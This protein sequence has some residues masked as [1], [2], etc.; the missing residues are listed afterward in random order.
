MPVTPK[1]HVTQTD[2]FVLVSMHVPHVRIANAE[3]YIDCR[4]FTF[5]CKPYLLKLNFPHD[6]VDDED[7][8]RAVFDP[9]ED[10]GTITAHLPKAEPGLYFKDLDLTT[11]LLQPRWTR[12]DLSGEKKDSQGKNSGIEVLGSETFSRSDEELREEKKGWGKGVGV[13]ATSEC[14][15]EQSLAASGRRE[16]CGGTVAP[17]H[18]GIDELIPETVGQTGEGLEAESDTTAG[19]EAILHPPCYGFNKRFSGFFRPLRE[20]LCDIVQLPDPDRTQPEARRAL[21]ISHENSMFNPDRYLADLYLVEDEDESDPILLEA[22]AHIPHWYNT[23]AAPPPNPGVTTSGPASDPCLLERVG[24]GSSLCTLPVESHPPPPSTQQLVLEMP[25][26]EEPEALALDTHAI[27]GRE[28][29]LGRS[30]FAGDGMTNTALAA[31]SEKGMDTV[32]VTVLV[33]GGEVMDEGAG[34]QGESGV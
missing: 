23:V 31:S 32:A 6:L 13:A 30:G 25:N 18:L 28:T 22:M 33:E 24:T 1:F 16:A 3:T 7:R 11:T 26:Q 12:N 27:A 34:A 2:D 14:G 19:A 29:S 10:G 20:D 9:N 17:V 8:C 5:Y 4:E 21:R 15:P